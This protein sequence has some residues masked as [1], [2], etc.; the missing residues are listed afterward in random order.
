[1]KLSRYFVLGWLALSAALAADQVK[2]PVL[3]QVP[4]VELSGRIDEVRLLPGQG[5]PYL[6][7]KTGQNTVRV[8]LGSMRYLMERGFNPK[9][10]AEVE[11]KG[12]KVG[13]DVYASS[14]TLPAENKTLQLRN[15]AGRPAWSGG[16]GNGRRG[17]GR[18]AR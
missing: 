18:G 7:V 1:M 4:K 10:G 14:V 12:Y 16:F 15:D 2:A 11:V 9:V 6:M 17:K 5:V 8:I 13:D 3:A